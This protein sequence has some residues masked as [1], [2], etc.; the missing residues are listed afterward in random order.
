MSAPAPR[1]GHAALAGPGWVLPGVEAVLF[2]KDGTIVDLHRFWGEV[3]RRRAR[4][5]VERCGWG[6]ERIPEVC[7]GMGLAADGRL[8][9]EGPTGLASR[10]EII[11][12]L[13]A[14]MRSQGLSCSERLVGEVFVEVHERFLP[15][16]GRYAALLPGAAVFAG[17]LKAAGVKT[18]VV[19]S[20][21]VPSAR[22]SLEHLGVAGLFD[23]IVGR[24]ST[25][26]AKASGVPARHAMEALGVAGDATVCLGDAPMDVTMARAA[27]CRAAVAVATGQVPLAVLREHTPYVAPT[28]EQVAVGAGG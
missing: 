8:L 21:T 5:L 9:P 18:A 14:R 28:L 3:I 25:A 2:D 24:D 11:R 7:R 1:P 12:E 4:A 26:A 10:E 27:G 13:C 15:E 22:A 6:E 17:A 19:T 23:L 20:D 16:T